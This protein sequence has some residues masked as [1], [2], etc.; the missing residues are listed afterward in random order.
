MHPRLM[1]VIEASLTVA[2]AER[3]ARGDEAFQA[4]VERHSRSLF[5]LAYR[6]TGSEADAEE[7]V[8]ETF[9][10]A[11]QQIESFEA[12]SNLGTWL[13]RIG[14]NCSID[15]LRRRQRHDTRLEPLETDSAGPAWSL[16]SDSPGPD[17]LVL[18]AQL[19]ARLT[20][21]LE[22]LSPSEKAA[23]VLRHYEDLSIEE[24][25]RSLGLGQS[26][27]KHAIFRAV[28]KLRRMLGPIVHSE[29]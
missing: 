24:I 20:R 9:L 7:V 5:R 11:F 21:A 8:Q 1:E 12:R 19:G 23:F 6:M 15:F 22:R 28:Q 4:L 3:R 14:V 16:A 17:R 29:K 26:A 27:V 13:Y 25:G 18:S 2:V 10:R